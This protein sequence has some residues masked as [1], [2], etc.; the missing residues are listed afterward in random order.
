MKLEELKLYLRIDGTED[1]DLLIALQDGAVD[2]LKN[3]GVAESSNALYGLAVK[4]LVSHWY[5]NRIS[6]AIGSTT[7]QLEYSLQAI[8]AQLMY[9]GG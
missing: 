1:D 5:E 9:G 8:M 4:L 7:K 2:Y 3:A 6:V